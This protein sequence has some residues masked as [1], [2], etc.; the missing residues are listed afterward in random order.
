MWTQLGIQLP[1]CLRHIQDT[2]NRSLL[3]FNLIFRWCLQFHDGSAFIITYLWYVSY[4]KLSKEVVLS[5]VNHTLAIK[6][7]KRASEEERLVRYKIL[8]AYCCCIF[9]TDVLMHFIH[10]LLNIAQYR[11]LFFFINIMLFAQVTTIFDK[12]SKAKSSPNITHKL[13]WW[14]IY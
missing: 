2:A 14:N 12:K 3:S 1:W 5:Y 9:L 10:F 4:W 13:I 11:L 8:K 7:M 6:I